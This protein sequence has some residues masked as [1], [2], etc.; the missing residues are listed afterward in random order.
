MP[1]YIIFN[2]FS[3]DRDGC[4]LEGDAL[5]AHKCVPAGK[6]YKCQCRP[7]FKLISD[8]HSCQKLDFNR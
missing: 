7:G 8:N 3:D 1:S 2:F 4:E 6:E 5:C